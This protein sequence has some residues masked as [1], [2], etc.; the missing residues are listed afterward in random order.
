MEPAAERVGI[1][2]L[3]LDAFFDL[4]LGF[5]FLL[6]HEFEALDNMRGLRERNG[7]YPIAVADDDVSG[8]NRHAPAG[9]RGI[10]F[11]GAV[12]ESGIRLDAARVNRDVDFQ[13][14]GHI[15]YQAV[16]DDGDDTDL[17]R[18][19]CPQVA[20]GRC[21]IVARGGDYDD[22]AFLCEVDYRH[23][24]E[25]VHRSAERRDGAAAEVHGRVQRLDCV[26]QANITGA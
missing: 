9:H 5:G 12:F 15:A 3:E 24:S 13:Q 20:D 4:G 26:V 10:Y 7:N 6:L 25:I 19:E 22:I 11:A 17:L 2:E 23:R 1:P 18:P 14:S 21:G 8:G 16:A